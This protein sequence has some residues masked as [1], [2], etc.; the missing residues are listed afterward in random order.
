MAVAGHSCVTSAHF[1][2]FLLALSL[3]CS[4]TLRASS[5]SLHDEAN[6]VRKTYAVGDTKKLSFKPKTADRVENSYWTLNTSF[7]L[8]NDADFA[9]GSKVKK[10]KE[11]F[12]L[13]IKNADRNNS[14][15]YSFM[16]NGSVVKQWRVYVKGFIQGSEPTSLPCGGPHH[17]EWSACVSFRKKRYPNC[18]SFPGPPLNVTVRPEIHSEKPVAHV[19]WEPPK[20]RRGYL[21]GYQV[22]IVG[23]NRHIGYTMCV[24]INNETGTQYIHKQGMRYRATYQVFVQSMPA[25]HDGADKNQVSREITFPASPLLTTTKTRANADEASP[26]LTT[27]TTRTNA[28]KARSSALMDNT[29]KIIIAVFCGFLGVV[30]CIC[31]AV[32]R[33]YF[34]QVRVTLPDSSEYK[35]SPDQALLN[36]DSG[37]KRVFILHTRCCDKC[38]HVVH[39]FAAV[40]RSTD[41]IEPS[42]DMWNTLDI[43][44]NVPRWYEEQVEKSDHVIVLGSRYMYRR[45]Q[46]SSEEGDDPLQIKCPLNFVRENIAQNPDTR[47]FIPAFFTCNGSKKDIPGFLSDRWIHKLPKEVDRV[48]FRIL[49]VEKIQPHRYQPIVVMGGNGHPFDERKKEME[50]AVFEAEKYHSNNLQI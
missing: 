47:R 42:I 18:K 10:G 6:P 17:S 37:R 19:K 49:D 34:Q 39:C 28:D 9:I 7:I 11:T 43:S 27:T 29:S 5:S 1:L 8:Q 40:L 31:F 48:I 46:N 3:E 35:P 25:L 14:G 20:K 4:M 13:K 38:S 41:L 32:Y 2:H 44:P 24:Q 12:W 50:K 15:L 33:V 16:I 23:K 45:C 22:H 21:W 26:L 36:C 30:V